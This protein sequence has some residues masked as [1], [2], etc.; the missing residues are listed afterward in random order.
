ML[1]CWKRVSFFLRLL[2]A[3]NTRRNHELDRH[4]GKSLCLLC[5]AFK[6]DAAKVALT[7]VREHHHDCFS[8]IFFPLRDPQDDFLLRLVYGQYAD[9]L[10]REEIER[11]P[12]QFEHVEDE[13]VSVDR[14]GDRAQVNLRSGQTLLANKVVLALGQGLSAGKRQNCPS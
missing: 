4:G 9:S 10:L 3:S 11:H 6:Q 13:V 5:Q 12:G 2:N 7:E 8:G 14:A 1:S